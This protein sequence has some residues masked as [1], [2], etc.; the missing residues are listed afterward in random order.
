MFSID[1]RS[2]V[3]L[4]DIRDFKCYQTFQGLKNVHFHQMLHTNDAVVLIGSKHFCYKW[5][6]FT[7]KKEQEKV[8]LIT[9]L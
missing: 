7:Q 3:K 6:R 2:L 8:V 5:Q 4:W 1:E 9:Q